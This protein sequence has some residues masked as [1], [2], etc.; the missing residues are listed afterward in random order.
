MSVSYIVDIAALILRGPHATM[1]V[2][3]ASGWSQSTF[4]QP[5]PNRNPLYRTLFNMAILVL[6]VEASG[7]V[8]RRLGGTPSTLDLGRTVVPLAGWRSRT[9]SSTPCRSRSPIALATN[10][11][12]G[13]SGRR[14]SR[15]ACPSYLLGAAAAAIVLAV[16]ESSGIWF[17]LLLLLAPLYLTY[18]VYRTRRRERSQAG[19]HSRSGARRDHHDGFA[20]GHP[21]VQPGRRADVRVPAHRTSSAATSRSC[22]R[23][24][25]GPSRARR[26]RPVPGAPA[27]GPLSRRQLELTG[28]R[29]DGTE[30]PVEL[31]VARVGRGK[32]P[33]DDGIRARHHRTA[34]SSKNSCGSRRSS[35]RSA[36]SPAA[37]RTTST[38]SS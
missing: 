19:R 3:A 20:A 5:T 4:N 30:F 22:C 37:S 32:P 8:Y 24:T 6:T 27:A 31:T 38:T 9:S 11:A 16:T 13:G 15:R 28:I 36:G 17:A 14:I 2:G 18:K 34:R 35:R 26:V 29:A 1:I 25:A 12:P 7:Q 21:R 23:P 33:R 10:R